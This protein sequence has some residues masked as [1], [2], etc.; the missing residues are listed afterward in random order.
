MFWDGGKRTAA[1]QKRQAAVVCFQE[2][3]VL[4]QI[5]LAGVENALCTLED[6]QSLLLQPPGNVDE[7]PREHLSRGISPKDEIPPG[8]LEF[9]S[10]FFIA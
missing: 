8:K 9:T 7:Y 10:F 2:V 5:L 3:S 4:G 6:V 1:R